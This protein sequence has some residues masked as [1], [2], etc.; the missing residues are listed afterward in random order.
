VFAG[1]VLSVRDDR[2]DYGEERYRTFGYLRGRMVHVAWT[3]RGEDRHVMSMRKCNAK[4]QKKLGQQ[5]GEG[6]RDDR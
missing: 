2:R 3:P 4:E 1:R 5:L 6:G